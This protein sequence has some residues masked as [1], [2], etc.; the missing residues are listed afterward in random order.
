[1]NTQLSLETYNNE[2]V[3]YRKWYMLSKN[4]SWRE[5][6]KARVDKLN[7]EYNVNSSKNGG[8]KTLQI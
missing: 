2:L 8:Q 3:K 6:V 7:K 1:M 4:L 5:W